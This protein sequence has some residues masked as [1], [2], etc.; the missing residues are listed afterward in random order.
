MGVPVS[1]NDIRGRGEPDSVS[2]LGD[3]A[4]GGI[5]TG[6]DLDPFAIANPKLEF[7][8]LEGFARDLNKCDKATAFLSERRMWDGHSIVGRRRF[9][10]ESDRLAD[11][12]NCVRI[13]QFVNKWNGARLRIDFETGENVPSVPDRDREL[14]VRPI[15]HLAKSA[16]GGFQTADGAFRNARFDPDSGRIQN[17][18]NDL[19][20]ADRFTRPSADGRDHTGDRRSQFKRGA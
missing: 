1:W 19:I 2:A 12:E 14:T 10:V 17:A 9:D 16:F 5:Q 6:K 18:E 20:R 8:P 13:V 11:A 15:E 7:A 3:D 4:F